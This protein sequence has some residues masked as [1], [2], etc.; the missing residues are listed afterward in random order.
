MK[1]LVIGK[2][3]LKRFVMRDKILRQRNECGN[4]ISNEN[5]A[6][7]QATLIR[8]EITA[9]NLNAWSALITSAP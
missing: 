7:P 9:D 4:A 6:L 3:N 1:L 5:L 2:S 8:L